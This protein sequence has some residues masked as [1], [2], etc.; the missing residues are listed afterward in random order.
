MATYEI[1]GMTKVTK[2]LEHDNSGLAHVGDSREEAVVGQISDR[3]FTPD[4]VLAILANFFYGFSFQMLIATIPVYVISLGGNQS[5]A[6]LVSGASFITALLFRPFVGWLTDAWRRR[7]L[8]LI[9]TSCYGLASVIYLLAGSIP[10]MLLG[11]FVHGFGGCCYS[12][13]A[14]AYV[15]D[16]APLK[17]RAEAIG[18]FSAVYALGLIIG[19][20]VGFMFIGA[21]GFRQLFYF[22]GGLAFTSF[23]IS[24]FAR[25][26]R[27]PKKIARE[28]WSPRTGI[29]AIN[30]LPATCITLCM[31]MG[32]G[33]VNAF[34]AIFAQP[35]GVANPG[36]YFTIQ[37][38]ALVFSRTFAGH[39]ADRYGRAVAIV[40]G[41]ILM[42]IAIAILPL[43]HGLPSFMI[44]AS[45][46]GLGF[47]MAQ[48]AT[49]AL[50]IDRVRPEQRG[51]A[52]G[53]YYIGLDLGISIGSIL[54]GIVGQHWGF[55]VMWTIAAAL[56]LLGLAGLL[57]D[58]RHVIPASQ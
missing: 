14:N 55:G 28:P 21:T 26:R 2:D 32:F 15:A 36:F 33:T 13:A 31:A 19:P 18:L 57:A 12:T 51:L 44:S 16:I 41:I 23:L 7:P 49:M 58:S 17:R 1:V 37:A 40:P 53:T 30:A 29:V 27:S 6:G 24:L 9:G 3:L 47:G 38:I 50:L 54:L 25:E 43:A 4:Y 34:I 5:E 52:V 22:T 45:L 48:P 35:R 39:F 46:I 11:R 56:T 10:F 42:A 8:V 20:V